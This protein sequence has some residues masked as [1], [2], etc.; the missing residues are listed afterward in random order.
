DDAIA[1][2]AVEIDHVASGQEPDVGYVVQSL[3][4]VAPVQFFGAVSHEKQTS[5]TVAFHLDDSVPGELDFMLPRPAVG[6]FTFAR[7]HSERLRF[8]FDAELPRRVARR[9]RPELDVA[10]RGLAG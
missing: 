10:P 9:L 3:E 1:D 8:P 6:L 7:R 2:P 4:L 5:Y